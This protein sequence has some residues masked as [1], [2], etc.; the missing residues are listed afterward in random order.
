VVPGSSGLVRDRSSR[1]ERRSPWLV[2]AESD[3]LQVSTLSRRLQHS[4]PAIEIEYGRR[5]TC[6]N[7]APQ[8]SVRLDAFNIGQASR[9]RPKYTLATA[10]GVKH[11]QN[12]YYQAKA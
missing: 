2:L 7:E 8:P 6:G 4:N 10:I 9:L 12:L 11:P 1:I 3:E 5:S